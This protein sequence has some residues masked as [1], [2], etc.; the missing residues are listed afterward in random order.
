[1]QADNPQ[2]I[3]D[4]VAFQLS[5]EGKSFEHLLA[6]ASIGKHTTVIGKARYHDLKN[7][8]DAVWPLF[9]KHGPVTGS[10]PWNEAWLKAEA[11]LQK[12]V[13]GSPPKGE[14]E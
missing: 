8:I 6:T 1:M 3:L 5:Q 9:D 4:E 12:V 13:G 14:K 10:E 11:A 2:A 7:A